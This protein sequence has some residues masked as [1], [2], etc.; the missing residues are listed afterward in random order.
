MIRKNAKRAGMFV[1]ILA[2]GYLV[3]GYIFH[4]LIFPEKRPDVST[5]FKPGHQFYSKAE[6]VLQT[7]VKQE[8]GHVYCSTIMEPH[9]GGPPEHIHTSFDETFEVS[10]GEL[11]LLVDGKVVKLKPGQT[12]NIPKGTPHKPF[13]ETADTLRLKGT[14]AFPE[15]FAFH[16]AQIYGVMD[17]DLNFGKSA[18][19]ILQMSLIGSYGFDSY[20]ADGPPVPMQKATSFMLTPLARWCGYKSFY[21]EYD[22]RKKEVV[23]L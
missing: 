7:V 14:I 22:I 2:A 23:K 12:F 5:Y 1:L 3:I 13:N 8:N 16:L 17:N 10:N 21:P 19:T 9:A 15:K 18:G 11:S 4:L 20:L 6:G